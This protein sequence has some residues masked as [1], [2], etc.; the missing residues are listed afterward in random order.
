MQRS[1]GSTT[2]W[3]AVV[4][5]VGTVFAATR[6][7]SARDVAVDAERQG[8]A[9]A[10]SA[11][12]T[13]RA[14]L[15]LIWATLTDY[16]HLAQFIPGMKR[17]RVVNRRGNTAVVEQTGEA[18]LWVFHYP[19]AVVV[20]SVEHY[21]AIIGVRVL[22]G[23]LRQLAGAYRIDTVAGAHDEFV[24]RWRGIIEP[25]ISLPL[26]L[27]APELRKAVA[28]QFLGMINEI[29]RRHGAHE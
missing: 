5:A 10:I 18:R 24:L 4:V 1:P 20:E 29:E 28:E 14:P 22:A 19:I 6:A 26:F 27:T 13:I 2:R 25:D 23:N 16:D 9:L 8:N 7:E 11:H 3:A 17:S 12:A 15:P 21:P